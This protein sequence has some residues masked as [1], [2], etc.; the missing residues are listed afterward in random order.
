MSYVEHNDLGSQLY[1]KHKRHRRYQSWRQSWTP[2]ESIQGSAD[3]PL[4]MVG[5]VGAM[6]AASK[7]AKDSRKAS[8]TIDDE[9]PSESYHTPL[10]EVKSGVDTS[11]P[12]E[13]QPKETDDNSV[14]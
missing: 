11:I 2:R 13:A 9:G 4:T 12:M 1:E 5:V 8:E 7:M 6:I 14:V 3:M 10:L